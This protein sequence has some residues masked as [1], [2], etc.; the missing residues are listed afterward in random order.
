[1]N[2]LGRPERQDT[3]VAHVLPIAAG[4]PLRSV[5]RVA[6]VQSPYRRNRPGSIPFAL[7]PES[8]IGGLPLIDCSGKECHQDPYPARCYN[9]NAGQL[10]R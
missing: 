3:S 4:R 1:M 6:A 10:S 7:T 5:R 2:F 9:A 8:A